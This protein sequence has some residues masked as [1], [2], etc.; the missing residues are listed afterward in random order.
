MTKKMLRPRDFA[1][2]RSCPKRVEVRTR[3]SYDNFENIDMH[4]AG[5][6]RVSLNGRP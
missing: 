4:T 1:T 2:N 6:G 5:A 3:F